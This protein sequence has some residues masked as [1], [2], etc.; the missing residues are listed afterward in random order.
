MANPHLPIVCW[1]R[2]KR[3]KSQKARC[4]TTWIW[5]VSAAS[6]LRAMP[7]KWVTKRRMAGSTF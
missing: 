1:R 4:W 7:F 3:F 2:Q 6:R 5:N